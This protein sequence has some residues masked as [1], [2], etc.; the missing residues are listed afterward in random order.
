MVEV[1]MAWLE[2]AITWLTDTIGVL[3]YPGIIILMALESSFFPFP[4]EVVVP[5]A[6][7]LAA[8][9]RMNMYL[10]IGSA[11]LGSLI[12][13]LVNYGLAIWVGR[14]FLEKYGRRF[15]VKMESLEKAEA[16]ME[17]HGEIS[18]FVGRLV[19]VIR[20]Y[21]SLPAGLGRMNL[22]KFSVYTALGA[23]IWCAILAYIGWLLGANAD[24]LSDDTVHTYTRRAFFILAPVLAIVIGAYV[25]RHRRA[26][27]KQAGNE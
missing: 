25:F 5:P 3:G 21:I 20:Q 16:Y 4:S 6:G 17:K 23:G 8:Q 9:G 11:T 2:T 14:P 22:F 10:V 26:A 24:V 19:P 1:M 18:M 27:L 12:G 13:A 15:F 7:F